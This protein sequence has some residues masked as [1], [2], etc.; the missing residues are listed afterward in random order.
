MPSLKEIDEMLLELAKKIKES[1]FEPDILIGI[2]RGGLIPAAVL[3]DRLNVE[4]EI[5]GVE[6][7]SGVKETK[8]RPEITQQILSD[9]D[10]KKVL[11]VDDVAD[12]GHSLQ[13]VKDYIKKKGVK[14]M[15]VCTLHYKPWS[16]VKPE[17]FLKET[18]AWIIYPWEIKET[19]IDLIKKLKERGLTESEAKVLIQKKGVPKKVID[20]FLG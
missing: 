7:Y 9:L 15:R 18:E 3:S 8:K 19:V 4:S 2:S 5:V 13:L 1:K 14:E 12:M 11:I 10:G 16:I 20:N 6:Y 17:Y